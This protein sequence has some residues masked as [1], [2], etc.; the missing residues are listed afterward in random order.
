M[1]NLRVLFWYILNIKISYSYQL[2]PVVRNNFILSLEILIKNF[3]WRIE[4]SYSLQPKE[5]DKKEQKNPQ[6]N[7]K[8]QNFL[9]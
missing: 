3:T 7:K 6:K 5:L 9:K 8:T 2:L 4:D 1:F